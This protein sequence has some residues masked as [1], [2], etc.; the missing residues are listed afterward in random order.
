M[1]MLK[2]PVIVSNQFIQPIGKKIVADSRN[3]IEFVFTF[4]GEIWK[5]INK[6]AV[7]KVNN[8]SY[9]VLLVNDACIVPYQAMT[10]TDGFFT[11]SVFGG[12]LITTNEIQIELIASGFELGVAPPVPPQDVYNQL[13][14]SVMQERAAAQAAKEEAQAAALESE[15]A[16]ERA[17]LASSLSEQYKNDTYIAKQNISIIKHQF[18]DGMITVNKVVENEEQRNT[19][20]L[21]RKNNEGERIVDEEIRK[22]NELTRKAD[23]EIRKTNEVI[24]EANEGN[25]QQ[26]LLF[27]TNL[28]TNGDFSGGTIG[29]DKLRCTLSIENGVAVMTS[30]GSDADFRQYIVAQ[31]GNIIYRAA[32]IKTSS[33]LVGI[34]AGSTIAKAHTGNNTFQWLSFNRVAS[35]GTNEHIKI[36]DKR[37]PPFDN[38]YISHILTINLTATF[39]A[40]N[41][42]TAAQ[43]DTLLSNFTN[44]WFNG[45]TNIFIPKHVYN[46]LTSLDNLKADKAQEAWITP[47]LLNG[48]GAALAT[49]PN[50]Y[51]NN[52]GEVSFRGFAYG[53][54]NNTVSFS[55]PAGY[56]PL[57]TV[58]YTVQQNAGVG[59]IEVY[60]N[61]NVYIKHTAT[62]WVSLSG[63]KFRSEG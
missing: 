36:L 57:N 8:L 29:Y 17:I 55:L 7:F 12:D 14:E 58:V 54:A 43:M 49:P 44:S 46:R 21:I 56:R 5:N 19:D 59:S 47:T 31:N 32:R 10:Q 22:S 9:N 50:Y 40:G 27:A 13:V 6:T 15:T 61:G 63:V 18:D 39:G 60:S 62:S 2:I 30:T 35:D 1:N 24:R 42:P 23:E 45:T 33:N 4:N 16:K 3:L 52:M 51:K 34:S 26:L 25:R 20:E 11:L 48:W 37:I 53:G 41:E 28:I 38:I